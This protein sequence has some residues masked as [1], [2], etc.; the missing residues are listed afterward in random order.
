VV[1]MPQGSETIEP[2]CSEPL[3][4]AV[5][6]DMSRDNPSTCCAPSHSR[7]AYIQRAKRWTPKRHKVVISAWRPGQCQGVLSVSS[8]A[9]LL[10]LG[11][12]H[13]LACL[14]IPHNLCHNAAMA[15]IQ[16]QHNT[17]VPI[18][19]LQL[20]SLQKGASFVSQ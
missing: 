1:Q 13:S 14:S 16:L 2:M 17:D 3:G 12:I 8:T 6:G 7:P 4:D 20:Q 19:V 15:D 9:Q 18:G 11:G 5:A 10:L